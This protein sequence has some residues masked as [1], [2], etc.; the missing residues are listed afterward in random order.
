[1]SME[2]PKKILFIHHGKGLG[3]APLSLLYLV[4]QLPKHLYQPVVA[5]LHHSEAVS[6]F[7]KNNIPIC[8]PINWNDFPHTK[9]WHFKWYHLHH[10]CRAILH[11]FVTFFFIAPR[12]YQQ[13]QPALVHLNTSSLIAWAGAA[14][15]R[16]I[17]VVWHIREPLADGY[18][19]LRKAFIRFCVE[20]FAIKII[21]ISQH[22]G[23][24]WAKSKKL[25]II[26]N[27]V[28]ADR[29]DYTITATTFKQEHLAANQPSVLFVGGCS[30]EKGTLPLLKSFELVLKQL[31]TT[32]L[33][34]AG[35]MP[36]E[37]NKKK[38]LWTPAIRYGE[39]VKKII[40]KYPNNIE[41]LGIIE[42]I[43]TVMAAADVIVFPA[44]V[45]HFARP[46]IEA[47]FMKKPVVASRLAPLEELVIDQKTGL[48]ITTQD[49]QAWQQAMVLLLSNKEKRLCMGE[50]AYAFCS[51]R[52]SLPTQ[53]DKIA[54]IYAT[55]LK[56]DDNEPLGA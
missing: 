46:I 52:F 45:G 48:L 33:L 24:P 51:E 14:W 50:A 40:K 35:Y 32:K 27:A 1:M 2:H 11:T 4:Q 17:P 43:P 44:T 28:P 31:P 34:L 55:I 13:E 47:G 54:K 15:L 9:I 36:I 8:G 26:Y 16:N 42:D 3:G 25:S 20:I 7:K 21:A 6:L 41:I 29:F 22:D 37:N 49:N 56:G 39:A 23:E 53:R 30:Q 19:G 12:L 10:L 18:L 38:Q 5:F